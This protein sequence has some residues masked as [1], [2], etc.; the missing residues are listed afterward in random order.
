V[1]RIVSTV[2]VVAL[3]TGTAVAFALTEGL[4]L[5]PT[6]IR[7]V[8]VAKVFSPVCDCPTDTAS[9]RVRL[10]QAD[11][12]DVSIVDS[13]RRVVSTIA[14]GER[15][16]AGWTELAWNGRDDAGRVLPEGVYRPRI[17]LRGS[18]ETIVLPNDIRI[19]VTPPVVEEWDVR[20]RVFSP[21]GDGRADRVV[22]RYRVD[23]SA[24]GM[25]FVDGER[26]G[27]T[28]FART[29]DVLPWYGKVEGRALDAATYAFT[30]A[31]RDPAGN[32]SARS[33]AVPV[34]IRYVTLGRDR[35]E[36]RADATFAIRV[37]SDAVRVGWR[38]GRRSGEAAP[39]TLRLRAPQRPGRHTLTVTANGRSASAAVF[40][41]ER[42]P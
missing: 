21:D 32:V 35:V 39:G 42:R 41:R 8:Q 17:H 37:S 40:V 12:L 3:L 13:S 9:I 19:D 11:V 10:R 26:R 14:R 31:A 24:R 23:E 5:Q 2:L 22:V 1:A 18:R 28:K 20:P 15:R 38:L 16:P 36:V 34:R 30:F 7:A 6:P 25:L 29:E 27:L 4:K 33:Q